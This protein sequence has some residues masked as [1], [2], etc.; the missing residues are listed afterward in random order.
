MRR[1]GMLTMQTVD[2]VQPFLKRFE[3]L[4][5]FG[6][7]GLSEGSTIFHPIRNAGTR[8][9]SLVLK[10][11]NYP[12]GSGTGNGGRGRMGNNDPEKA[13]PAPKANCLMVSLRLSFIYYDDI[14]LIENITT[15]IPFFYIFYINLTLKKSYF[16]FF[17]LY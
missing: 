12:L 2:N 15:F 1:A 4:D 11:E 8:F 9:K 13:A 14:R 6:Q 17:I 10:K 16:F 7:L 3:C 5:R